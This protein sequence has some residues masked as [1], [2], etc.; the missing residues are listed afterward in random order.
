MNGKIKKPKLKSSTPGTVVVDSPTYGRHER[1]A[2][3]THRP[4]ELNEAL[5]QSAV[6][7]GKAVQLAKLVQYGIDPYREDFRG[8]LMWQRLLSILKRQYKERKDFDLQALKGFEIWKEKPLKRFFR[9]TL[10]NL[11]QFDESELVLSFIEY[12]DFK[13][14]NIVGMRVE[15]I[16]VFADALEMRTETR[17]VFD[18]KIKIIKPDGHSRPSP[19]NIPLPVLPGQKIVCLKITGCYIDKVVSD[20]RLMGMRIIGVSQLK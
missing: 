20:N 2:R 19:I 15:V 13:W 17:L 7:M 8:G 10:N 9:Q 3:G 12:P 16:V 1:A 14:K 11:L 5:K 18:D 4:A 6:D